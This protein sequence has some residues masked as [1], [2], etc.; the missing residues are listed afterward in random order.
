MGSVNGNNAGTG[1]I[2]E[3]GMVAGSSNPNAPAGAGK[4]TSG[5]SNIGTA[6]G[7]NL[8]AAMSRAN[9]PA[10]GA[11]YADKRMVRNPE[12][13]SP[14]DVTSAAGRLAATDEYAG[15]YGSRNKAR[16]YFSGLIDS[17]QARLEGTP[18]GPRR[19]D[20]LGQVREA[21]PNFLQGAFNKAFDPTQPPT[22]GMGILDSLGYNYNMS[23]GL[24]SSSNILG[25]A[26]SAIT[27]FPL[28]GPLLDKLLP[29]SLKTSEEDGLNKF[30]MPIYDGRQIFENQNMSN[31]AGDSFLQDLRNE[32]YYMP[33]PKD[34]VDFDAFKILPTTTNAP[35]GVAFD[36]ISGGPVDRFG[37]PIMSNVVNYNPIIETE[38][39]YRTDEY[40]KVSPPAYTYQYSYPLPISPGGAVSDVNLADEFK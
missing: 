9:A 1:S 17:Q 7:G 36:Q 5:F 4:K 2:R 16:D 31:I 26:L 13:F 35:L 19:L 34:R 14:L 3:S 29:E 30:G 15:R 24:P 32:T 33:E 25:T 11:S 38:P 21:G 20:E 40:G 6:Y 10:P 18:Y 37:N 28:A 27:G 23:Q 12:R 39:L 8:A 22:R